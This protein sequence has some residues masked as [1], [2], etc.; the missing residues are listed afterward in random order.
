VRFRSR[1]DAVF[2]AQVVDGQLLAPMD[3]SGYSEGGELQNQSAHTPKLA[4]LR[5]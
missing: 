4:G 5:A 2:L 1:W 3:P